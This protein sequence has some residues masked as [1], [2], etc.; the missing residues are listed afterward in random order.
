[1]IVETNLVDLSKIT[2]ENY[3]TYNE[4]IKYEVPRQWGVR[5]I[6][7][8]LKRKCRTV[9]EK[10]QYIQYIKEYQHNYYMKVTKKKRQAKRGWLYE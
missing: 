10:E 8:K 2:L 4:C 3:T 1:M 5:H 9:E 7:R 6:K